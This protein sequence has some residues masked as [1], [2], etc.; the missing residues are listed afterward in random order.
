MKFNLK[1]L[2]ILSVFLT[3]GCGRDL[4][5]DSILQSAADGESAEKY[6]TI[7]EQDTFFKKTTAD[8]ATLNLGSEKCV[9]TAS[10]K[11]VL[12]Q[13]PSMEGGHLF[14]QLAEKIANCDLTQGY[15]FRSHVR[16]M[17]L[18]SEFSANMRA[19]LDMIA[20]AEGTEDS[21]D[22]IFSFVKFYSFTGHPRR[23]ICSGGYCSDAAGRYQI[24][25]T[26]WDDVRK[27]VGLDDFTPESQ[28]RAAVQLI[29][30]RGAY[31]LVEQIEN[32][33][34]FDNAVYAVR[35]EWAS[36]PYS[37][38]GQPIKSASLLWSKF[39]NYKTRY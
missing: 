16:V 13:H 5:G 21:Y 10:S 35:Y 36:M 31:R 29:K 27:E 28:D 32:F 11:V 19:F 30:W 12:T 26:T 34:D 20:F 1:W 6:I 18:K 17:S 22:Y 4:N 7:G 3:I 15:V 38:Y 9:L 24:K 14:V 2:A 25:S 23:L 33:D 39:K 37:P 8:S